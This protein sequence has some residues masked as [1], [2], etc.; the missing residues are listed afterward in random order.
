MVANPGAL[1]WFLPMASALARAEILRLYCTPIANTATL[2]RRT[3]VLPK[4]IAGPVQ[5]ELRLR[6]VPDRVG[7][8]RIR[9]VSTPPHLALV[10]LARSVRSPRALERGTAVAQR[11]FDRASARIPRRGDLGVIASTGSA[12]ATLSRARELG[13]PA[14]LD[15]PIAHH[16]FSEKLLKEEARLTPEFAGT[17][18][19][20]ELPRQTRQRLDREI[21]LADRVFVNSTFAVRSFLEAGIPENKLI[22]TP[23]GVDLEMF[24]PEG[25]SHGLRERGDRPFRVLFAGQITQRKGISYLLEAFEQARLPDAE[26]VFLGRPVGPARSLLDRPGVQFWPPVGIDRL[27]SRYR[28]CDVFVLPSLIE[29]FPQT[30]AIA[31]ACGLPVI[32]SENTSGRDVVDDGVTG[33]VVPIRNTQSIVERLGHLR[34][35]EN[36]RLAM[37]QAARARI[38]TFTW[39]AYGERIVAA[40]K[41]RPTSAQPCEVIARST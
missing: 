8:H 9:Q 2:D 41:G 28:A 29:G 31:M 33:Y 37:G 17:L 14:F 4:W 26:L 30:A 1:R 3:A 32:L 21:E 19:F 38:G 12:L 7:D 36:Q 34:E 11:R 16:R 40:V 24:S 6:P 18:Q 35:N 15:Y 10:A 20:W 25:P 13:V 39:E 27:A 5:R 23:F 22:M